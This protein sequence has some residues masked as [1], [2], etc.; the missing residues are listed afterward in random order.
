MHKHASFG[1]WIQQ[2]RKALDLT[3]ATGRKTLND[4]W[5]MNC[6]LFLLGELAQLQSDLERARALR[7]QSLTLCR[8]STEAS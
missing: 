1:A 7:K 3:Q 5:G 8:Q 4:T 2:R 6:A